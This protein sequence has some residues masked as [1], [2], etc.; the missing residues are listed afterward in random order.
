M[1]LKVKQMDNKKTEVIEK[2][3]SVKISITKKLE[4]SG[5]VKTYGF[6]P[7]EAMEQSKK[8]AKEL[9]ELIRKKNK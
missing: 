6:T 1:G 9:E 3:H 2:Q 4:W 8:L 5:E 7:G